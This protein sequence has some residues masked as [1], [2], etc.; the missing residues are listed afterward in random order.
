MIV[1]ADP[2]TG[3]SMQ[4]VCR[5]CLNDA[6][7]N[8]AAQDLSSFKVGVTPTGGLV[9]WCNKH[10]ALVMK[11]ENAE[12]QVELMKIAH[13]QCDDCGGTGTIH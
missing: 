13:S 12:V 10:D 5:L 8:E 6:R 4:L 9:V 11:V 7:S 2:K 1:L 3:I